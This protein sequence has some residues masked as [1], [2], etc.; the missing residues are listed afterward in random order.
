MNLR[1]GYLDGQTDG[2]PVVKIALSQCPLDF[3]SHC[4][5]SFSTSNCKAVPQGLGWECS[6]AL[7]SFLGKDV[8]TVIYYQQLDHQP[9][10][11]YVHTEAIVP[12]FQ[13][14]CVEFTSIL[15]L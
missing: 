3:S 11:P 1:F 7:P 10:V 2:G 13:N 8:S 4:Y 6:I 14:F 9:M 15:R 5:I 12:L